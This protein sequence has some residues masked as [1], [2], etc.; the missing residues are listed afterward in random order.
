MQLQVTAKS[1]STLESF[2]SSSTLKRAKPAGV[3][4]STSIC[5]RRKTSFC[6]VW[7]FFEQ[8]RL[9][10]KRVGLTADVQLEKAFKRVYD[11]ICK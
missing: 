7:V 4:K 6:S 2:P 11:I 3:S 10:K 9:R 1:T 5:G 8:W